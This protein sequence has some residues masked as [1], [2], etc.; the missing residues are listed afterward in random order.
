MFQR[1]FRT[2]IQRPHLIFAFF[3]LIL[4]LLSGCNLFNPANSSDISSND[5]DA[6][7]YQGQV[8][9][10]K[11]EYSNSMKYF[12]KAVKADSTKSE[13]WFGF[14]KAS[15]YASGVNP[16]DIIKY[17]DVDGDSLPFMS[18]TDRKST[19]LN[20]SHQI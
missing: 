12:S 11:G 15:M 1:L 8:L 18:L 20:S 14:A 7:I 10:R 9:F 4:S 2:K 6:L 3:Y 19:R 16:F 5:A 17:I 13:A